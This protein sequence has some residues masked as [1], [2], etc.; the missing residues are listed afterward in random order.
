LCSAAFRLG[1]RKRVAGFG[2]M[3]KGVPSID[4]GCNTYA[5]PRS[6]TNSDLLYPKLMLETTRLLLTKSLIPFWK[7]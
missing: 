4:Q 5:D 1:V 6:I 3:E 7:I 2:E